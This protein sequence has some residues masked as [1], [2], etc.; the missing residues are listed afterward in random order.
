MTPFYEQYGITIYHGDNVAVM[1]ELPGES[2]DLVV[3]SPPYDDLRIR[4]AFVGLP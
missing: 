1:R 2:I 3:T 4:R